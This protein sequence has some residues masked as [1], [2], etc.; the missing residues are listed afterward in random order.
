HRPYKSK[1]TGWSLE[2]AIKTTFDKALNKELTVNL[3]SCGLDEK[4][5]TWETEE[6]KITQ[7][8]KYCFTSHTSTSTTMIEKP[9]IFLLADSHGRN[10]HK[11]LP[12]S[13][14]YQL[15]IEW[16]S[17]MKWVDNYQENMSAIDALTTAAVSSRLS[18]SCALILLLGTNSIRTTPYDQIIPQI[19]TFIVIIRTRF[20]NI[21]S[22]AIINCIPCAK[23][24]NRFP[25]ENLQS[26][27]SKY[28]TSLKLL[29]EAFNVHLIDP[30]IQ[31]HYLNSDGIHI[32]VLYQD[33]LFNALFHHCESLTS[34]TITVT[35]HPQSALNHSTLDDHVNSNNLIDT[36]T[37][38][39]IP[40]ITTTSSN[41]INKDQQQQPP[42]EK[43]K[44]VRTA[45]QKTAR[46]RKR[47]ERA[48]EHLLE[49]SISRTICKGWSMKL[50]KAVLTHYGISSYHTPNPQ[51][52]KLEIRLKTQEESHLANHQL[53]D[54]AFNEENL[55]EWLGKQ[56]PEPEL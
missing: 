28:N 11:R 22:I 27:I 26:N 19:E 50:I 13:C 30:Q 38:T 21:K 37:T 33:L 49:N 4:L 3:W 15:D 35:E 7:T 45:E 8:P 48:K 25:F 46:N 31:L 18:P 29:T 41:E 42:K 1:A 44:A 43:T 6:D 51:K 40:S 52:G 20:P 39:L 53:P 17:G 9:H 2:K 23:Q 5:K 10:I 56:Q 47:H 36:T 12:S 32:D 16:Q 14:N 34:H 24:T 54:D 55:T